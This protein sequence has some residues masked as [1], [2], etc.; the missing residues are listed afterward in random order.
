MKVILLSGG[1]GQTLW[2][3]SNTARSMQY[4]KLLQSPDQGYESMIQRV[5]RQLNAVDLLEHTYLST[6][7]DQMDSIHNQ[8]GNDV[9]LI[10]EPER[11]NT[12]PAIALAVAYLHSVEKIEKQEVICVLPVDQYVDDHFFQTLKKLEMILQPSNADI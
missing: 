7:K 8:L 3:L 10:V 4:L 12:F 5:W 11:R 1:A 6:N 9:H 2:P